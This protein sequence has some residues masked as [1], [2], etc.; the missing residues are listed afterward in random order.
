VI[1]EGTGS[2]LKDRVGGQLLEVELADVADRE[3]ACKALAAVGCRDLSRTSGRT[4]SCSPLR[5]TACN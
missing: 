4:G 3:R 1:A 2:E 5:A